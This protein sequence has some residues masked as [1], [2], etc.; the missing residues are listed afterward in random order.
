MAGFPRPPWSAIPVEQIMR[1]R[2]L[3]CRADTGMRDLARTMVTHGVH[4]VVVVEHDDKGAEYVSGIVTDRALAHA[5]LNAREPLAR[6]LVDPEST[7][8]SV[9][10]N[11]QQAAREMLRT[12]SAHAVVIDGR[13]APIGMLSTLDLARVVAWGHA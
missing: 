12:G 9:G 4:A 11:L 7:T 13:G 6:E 2:V 8:V 5:G 10:W 3:T 1:A